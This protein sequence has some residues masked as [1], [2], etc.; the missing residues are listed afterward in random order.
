M[1]EF[2]EMNTFSLTGI[3]MK[4]FAITI[5][6]LQFHKHIVCKI[7]RKKKKNLQ[8]SPVCF[9]SSELMETKLF[10]SAKEKTKNKIVSENTSIMPRNICLKLRGKINFLP[11]RK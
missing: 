6:M 1:P 2:G 8:K 7:K 4:G 11:K 5:A 9:V 3:Q 10:T